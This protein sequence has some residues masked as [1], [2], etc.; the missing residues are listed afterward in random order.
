MSH[1]T[2]AKLCTKCRSAL[3]LS[4]FAK[5]PAGAGGLRAECRQCKAAA[6]RAYLLKKRFGIAPEDYDAMLAKQGGKCALCDR[7]T[8]GGRW[9]RFHVDHCHATGRV[10]GLL[11]RS[12]NTALGALG[13]SPEAIRRA[14]A[15]VQGLEVGGDN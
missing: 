3:P 1:V 9:P 6:D 12:C 14:L 11:C 7:S 13:D 5:S 2:P 4:A 8:P 10:R 15:Y